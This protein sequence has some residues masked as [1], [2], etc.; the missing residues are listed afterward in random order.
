M[1]KVCV[2][3]GKEFTTKSKA[4]CCSDE[5][6]RVYDRNYAREYKRRSYGETHASV[7]SNRHYEKTCAV[8]GAKFV[9]YTYSK[10]CSTHCADEAVRKQ[11]RDAYA[12]RHG[13]VKPR[14]YPLHQ[15]PKD[16]KP[17]AKPA[18]QP[19]KQHLDHL[20]KMVLEAEAAGLSYGQYMAQQRLRE[21]K[22]RP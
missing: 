4:V 21:K 2:I 14:E 5:C 22:N 9:G 11:R 17:E 12:A 8:C 3:C 20:D 18:P 16:P 1:I 19:K 6:R 15:Q 13:G 7:Q 10:Y